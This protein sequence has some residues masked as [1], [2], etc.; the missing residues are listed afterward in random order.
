MYT[1]TKGIA[2]PDLIR[3]TRDINSYISESENKYPEE[4]WHGI[5]ERVGIK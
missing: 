3:I 5:K 1:F 2:I 4:I